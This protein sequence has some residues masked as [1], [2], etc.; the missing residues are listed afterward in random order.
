MNNTISIK[1]TREGLTITLGGGELDDL[2]GDLTRH[3]EQQG[4]FFRGGRV[5]LK[6]G[7]RS[8]HESELAQIDA[9]LKQHDMILRTVVTADKATQAASEAL[10]LRLIAQEPETQAETPPEPEASPP[11][12][13]TVARYMN[14]SRGILVRHWVRSGQVVRH[15]G[16]VVVIGDVNAGAQIVAGGDI[17]VWGRLSGTAHAGSMGNHDAVVCALDMQPMQLRIGELVARSEESSSHKDSCPEMA[18]VRDE[19]IV[20]APWNKV[21]RGV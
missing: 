1:G 3:L 5:A 4:A 19:M 10:G 11:A 15:T 20:V 17:V 2:L 13:S 6:V 21:P 12:P 9:L 16:H 8:V 14:G 18:Y 7:D